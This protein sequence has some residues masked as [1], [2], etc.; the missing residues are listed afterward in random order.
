M[1]KL[2]AA[3]PLIFVVACGPSNQEIQNA[4][5][6]T[7]NI[8]TESRSMDAVILVKEINAAREKIGEDVFL[9]SH[10]DISLS[11]KHDLCESLVRNDDDYESRLAE[12]QNQ[13][14]LELAEQ[15]KVLESKKIGQEKID[16]EERA[17]TA[18]TQAA[19]NHK[20]L[21]LS[22]LE[23]KKS[24]AAEKKP[25][26]REKEERIIFAEKIRIRDERLEAYWRSLDKSQ[27]EELYPQQTSMLKT[28]WERCDKIEV[29]ARESCK[30]N[31]RRV[32]NRWRQVV[33]ERMTYWDALKKSNRGLDPS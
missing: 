32:N 6:I 13:E 26:W 10:T 3:L 29:F 31:W 9:G 17:E 16:R 7:C 21:K 30:K 28:G 19:A 15:E 2:T 8:M 22:M 23:E 33:K 25:Y 24:I 11:F 27:W 20:H 4:T 1:S 12:L 14:A 5:T 18:R